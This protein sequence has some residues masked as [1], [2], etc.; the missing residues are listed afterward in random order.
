LLTQIE[1]PAIQKQPPYP[2]KVAGLKPLALFSSWFFLSFSYQITLFG[3]IGADIRHNTDGAFG[4]KGL[5]ILRAAVTIGFA[6][7]EGFGFQF[8]YGKTSKSN[9]DGLKYQLFR[10]KLV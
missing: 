8:S 7:N 6:L 1:A 4:G 5:V 2:C 10:M 3:P 9:T